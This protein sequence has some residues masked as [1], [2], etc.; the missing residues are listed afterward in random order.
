M[1]WRRRSK[2]HPTLECHAHSLEMSGQC[3]VRL[4]V[5]KTNMIGSSSGAT[6]TPMV[7]MQTGPTR[8]NLTPSKSSVMVLRA[9]E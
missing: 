8:H 7:M 1:V 9:E 3:L 5:S 6:F 4:R 2:S